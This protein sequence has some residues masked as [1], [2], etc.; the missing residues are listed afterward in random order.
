MDHL[1][2]LIAKQR[3][4]LIADALES[5]MVAKEEFETLDRLS[6]L[7]EERQARRRW[8]I[9]VI[10]FS[11]LV[12]ISFLLWHEE[13]ET[14]VELDATVTEFG[15]KLAQRR[16][17]LGEQLLS[18]LGAASLAG[19]EVD[20]GEQFFARE[21]ETCQ[22]NMELEGKP[23]NGDAITLQRIV[24]QKGW[25]VHLGRTRQDIGVTL[26]RPSLAVPTSDSAEDFTV[27]TS[28]RGRTMVE[29]ICGSVAKRWEFGNPT[30]S[31]V[32]IHLGAKSNLRLT[33]LK[34]QRPEFAR[35]IEVANLDLDLA[36]EDR[37]H[38]DEE[39]DRPTLFAGTVYLVALNGKQIPIR[40]SEVLTFGSSHGQIRTISLSSP[41][42]PS[43]D[44]LQ[45]QAHVEVSNM[46]MGVEPY[47][48]SLM[49]KWLEL[50]AAQNGLIL[51]WGTAIYVFG[52]V[53]SILR[54]FKVTS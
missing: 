37:P 51:L 53:Y 6:K 26:A 49:P 10:A 12:I 42:T 8:L 43:A 16:P 33:P 35:Q 24:A 7:A 15:F 20:L 34:G 39:L 46:R 17:I 29:A 3:E 41:G 36:P 5:G 28:L 22:L 52:I 31:A 27:T 32:V 48:R 50:A 4:K 44:A 47:Q 40:P 19:I 21:G 23:R 14:E 25:Q 18:A 1:T 38:S 13:K 2:R 54:W 9:P 11:T 45:L 30:P